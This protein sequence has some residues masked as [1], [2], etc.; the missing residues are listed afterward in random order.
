V[1]KELLT[2]AR[3]AVAQGDEERRLVQMD[4]KRSFPIGD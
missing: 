4:P 2:S 3:Y 1:E